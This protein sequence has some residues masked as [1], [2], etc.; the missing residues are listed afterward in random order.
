MD[1]YIQSQVTPGH[2]EIQGVIIQ[3]MEKR[4]GEGW[5]RGRMC[6]C[7]WGGGGVIILKPQPLTKEI[8]GWWEPLLTPLGTGVVYG[9]GVEG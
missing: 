6:V 5:I 8:D 4:V 9:E 7:V 1:I 2:D 3:D